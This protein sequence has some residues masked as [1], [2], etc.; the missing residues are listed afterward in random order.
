MK[1]HRNNT[2]I[3]LNL[4]SVRNIF[5]FFGKISSI[6]V[7]KFGN[8]VPEE[9]EKIFPLKTVNAIDETSIQ[10]WHDTSLSLFSCFHSET[11]EFDRRPDCTEI[12]Y[13]SWQLAPITADNFISF[14]LSQQFVPETFF[15]FISFVLQSVFIP[16]FPKSD[17]IIFVSQLEYFITV[18]Y[19]YIIKYNFLVSRVI[20]LNLN[21]FTF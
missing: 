1:H 13:Y 15:V 2:I 3:Q 5:F 9:S 19:K 11:L 6:L 18:N 10:R 14:D 8:F 16:P 20:V 4:N 7:E 21:C 17:M 12:D